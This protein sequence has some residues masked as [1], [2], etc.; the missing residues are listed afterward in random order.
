METNIIGKAFDKSPRNLR[1]F[2]GSWLFFSVWAVNK[3]CTV[4]VCRNG[5]KKRPDLSYCCFLVKSDDRKKWD[6]LC[7]WAHKKFE[8]LIDPRIC[9]LDFNETDIASN[10]SGHKNIP[11]GCYPT[12]FNP[13]K[14]KNT[15]SAC[16]KRPDNRKRCFAERPKAMKGKALRLLRTNSSEKE[17]MTRISH[18]EQNLATEDTQKLWLWQHSQ[19]SNLRTESL[20]LPFEF[21]R[22]AQKMS[23]SC[24]LSHSTVQQYLI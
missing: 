18:L 16:S 2:Y 3:Y 6:V 23:G 24:L 21:N 8:R 12:I 17:F 19:R 13:T 22:N 7:K 14:A 10:I 4:A 1:V 5:S 11:S 15:T 9:S 20:S